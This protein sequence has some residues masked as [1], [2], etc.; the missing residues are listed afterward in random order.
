[1]AHL[2]AHK[3]RQHDNVLAAHSRVRGLIEISRKKMPH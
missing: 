3:P 2:F 1:M